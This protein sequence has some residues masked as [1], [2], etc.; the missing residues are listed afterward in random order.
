M[1][2]EQK[3]QKSCPHGAWALREIGGRGRSPGCVD[4]D[5]GA[6][7]PESG[8]ASHLDRG[9][10]WGGAPLAVSNRTAT[11]GALGGAFPGSLGARGGSAEEVTD[12]LRACF[13]KHCVLEAPPAL[14]AHRL[15]S[16]ETRLL[17]RLHLKRDRLGTARAWGRFHGGRA[18]PRTSHV[19]PVPLPTLAGSALCSF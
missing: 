16:P 10:R 12:L 4:G 2:C 1:C 9:V 3:R 8:S 15:P 19:V 14:S 13:Q 6:M 7:R 17:A 11:H 18:A 5:V